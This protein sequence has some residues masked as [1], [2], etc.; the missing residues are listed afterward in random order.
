MNMLRKLAV[1]LLSLIVL[2]NLVSCELIPDNVVI[3]I[4]CGGEGY[5]DSKGINYEKVKIITH[6]KK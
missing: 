2:C 1:G 6:F 5:E 4:N 3:A